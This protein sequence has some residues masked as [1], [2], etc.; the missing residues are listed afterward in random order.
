MLLPLD[1][2]LLRAGLDDEPLEEPVVERGLPWVL[3]DD[4]PVPDRLLP[5]ELLVDEPV[6]ERETVPLTLT[7]GLER[8]CTTVRLSPWMATAGRR[9]WMMVVRLDGSDDTKRA[10]VRLE[11]YFPF[12]FFLM[13]VVRVDGSSDTA[14][15]RVERR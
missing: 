10:R 9:L 5:C 2:L 12:F 4:A 1:P 14:I 6:V 11:T 15:W 7:P 3:V 8:R 13:M